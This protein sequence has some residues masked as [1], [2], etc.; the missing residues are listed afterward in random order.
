MSSPFS[1]LMVPPQETER[2][3]IKNLI[4]N[5][6]SKDIQTTLVKNAELSEDKLRECWKLSPKMTLR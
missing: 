2:N 1:A 5:I 6:L 3:S 4:E